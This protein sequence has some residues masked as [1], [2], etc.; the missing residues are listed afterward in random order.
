MVR[1]VF[2]GLYV[3]SRVDQNHIM[4]SYIYGIS[5]FFHF[6][7]KLILTNL[8]FKLVVCAVLSA[9]S[10]SQ[11]NPQWSACVENYLH[12]KFIFIS[13][14]VIQKSIEA[15]VASS[16]QVKQTDRTFWA[17]VFVVQSA[18]LS[19]SLTSNAVFS[20]P[21]SRLEVCSERA[22]HVAKLCWK[23]L[24]VY[25]TAESLHIAF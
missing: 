10:F 16:F 9:V 1:D 21:R 5:F 24:G 7:N 12:F 19:K 8:C 20:P 4:C 14:F 13:R 3:H 15:E 23:E 17:G 11:L 22:K 18:I 6:Q 2:T 25:L